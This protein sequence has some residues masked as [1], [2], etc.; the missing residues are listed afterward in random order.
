MNEKTKQLIVELLIYLP[1]SL[2]VAIVIVSVD[3]IA[4]HNIKSSGI[5]RR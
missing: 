3:L 4:I 1:V 5:D 2:F